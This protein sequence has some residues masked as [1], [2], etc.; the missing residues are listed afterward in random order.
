MQ[1]ISSRILKKDI[2]C[3]WLFESGLTKI[4]NSKHFELYHNTFHF[5]RKFKTSTIK[6]YEY[7]NSQ[8]SLK[9]LDQISNQLNVINSTNE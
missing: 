2:Q 5:F 3:L 8:C 6:E 4:P 9:A 1:Y 7:V